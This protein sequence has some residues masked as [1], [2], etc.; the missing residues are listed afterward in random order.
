MKGAHAG[1]EHRNG[2]AHDPVRKLA[3][4]NNTTTSTTNKITTDTTTAVTTSIPRSTITG[5]V[6]C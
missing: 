5:A 4:T 3:S 6:S 2:A 1:A